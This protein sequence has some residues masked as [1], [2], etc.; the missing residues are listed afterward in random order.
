MFKKILSLFI[1]AL[2]AVSFTVSAFA[3]GIADKA[4][5]EFKLSNADKKSELYSDCIQASLYCTGDGASA[6]T[7]LG[8]TLVIDAAVLDTV[9][10]NTGK[11]NTKNYLKDSVQLGN[12]FALVPA[13]IKSGRNTVYF[14]FG[15]TSLAGYN[16]STKELYIFVCGISL[17]GLKL[18]AKSVKVADIYLKL[19]ENKSFSASSVRLMKQSEF[20][21]TAECPAPAIY[22]CE[23]SSKTEGAEICKNTKLTIS[24]SLISSGKTETEKQTASSVAVSKSEEEKKIVQNKKSSLNELLKSADSISA[25]ESTPQGKKLAE[26]VAKAKAVL[27]KE[28]VSE[29]EIEAAIK[30]LQSALND[31]N[32]IKSQPA[33]KSQN[34]ILIIVLIAVLLAAAVVSIIV[35]IV[36]NKKHKS[37]AE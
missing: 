18:P 20:R 21:N 4:A 19:K 34:K 7:T 2:I 35:I 11:V 12:D 24:S 8:C 28:N 33:E 23:I 6:V 30:D 36:K 3:A 25:D 37:K 27:G 9:D 16:A 13:G 26:A 10:Y 5:F 32:G 31:Y 14:D 1:A 22:P 15:A 29:A 17:S